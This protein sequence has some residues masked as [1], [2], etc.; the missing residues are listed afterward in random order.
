MR[1][2]FSPFLSPFRFT[3]IL[4]QFVRRDILGRYRGSL[5]GIGWAFVTPILMLGVY[6]F[7]F[8]GVFRARWP[9]AEEAGGIAFAL[10]LFAGL[11]V[12]NLFSEVAAQAP[13]LVVSQPNLV[14]KVA[15]P[16]EILPFVSLGSGLF[17][18]MLSLSVLL[19]GTVLVHQHLPWTVLLLPLVLLPLLPLLLGIAWFFSALGVFVRDIAQ[20]IGLC[21]NLLMFLSPIFY[22]TSTLSPSIQSWMMINPLAPVIENVRRVIFSGTVPE[23]GSWCISLIVSLFVAALGAAFFQA[24]RREF[25]DVL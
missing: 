8:V 24:T 7:V 12:F 21:I 23:W 22:S 17:H 3:P 4:R 25:A 14:K 19:L 6:T 1:H 18:L 5:L 2:L 9:G 13:N 20:M 15:F 11:M 10:Q 16:L